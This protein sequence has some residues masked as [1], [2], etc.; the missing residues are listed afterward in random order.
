MDVPAVH[1]AI[2]VIHVFLA[3]QSVSL[4][5]YVMKSVVME[6]DL[7][8]LVTMETLLMEMVAVFRAKLRL[9]TSV[10]EDLLTQ[11]ISVAELYL[12]L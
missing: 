3:I 6:R 7:H 8:F 12:K 9:D 5:L 11:R 10:Q 1:H 4:L 2:H